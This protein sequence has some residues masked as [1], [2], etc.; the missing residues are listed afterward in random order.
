MDILNLFFNRTKF[1]EVLKDYFDKRAAEGLADGTL[2]K[3]KYFH[4]NILEFL[5]ANKLESIKASRIKI[6]T[7]MRMEA[8]LIT[9]RACSNNYASRHVKHCSEAI[10]LAI[11]NEK[12]KHNSI[13][14][15][16]A[17]QDKVNEV[18]SLKPEEIKKIIHYEYKTE[19]E[20]FVVVLFLFQC[21]TGISY[22]DL[23]QYVIKMEFI[24][25]DGQRLEIEMI[26]GKN[27][28][29]R[30]KNKKPYW[31]EFNSYAKEIHELFNGNL[32]Y[33][34][35]QTYNNTIKRISRRVGIENWEE[36]TTH[37]GRKTYANLRFRQGMSLDGIANELGNTVE[38]LRKHYI[39]TSPDRML[40]EIPKLKGVPI[41]QIN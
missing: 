1:V 9:N 2:S 22:C 3:H 15:M 18:I 32:P 17:K 10:D 26:T 11:I 39:E 28:S 4:Q 37:V 13:S 7:M 23:W 33:V 6:S 38:V 12:C 20:F 30:G 36:M 24:L 41:F 40:Y 25:I 16:V 14:V 31:A 5:K 21:F 8:W 19:T 34:S 35:V 27:R 29:G